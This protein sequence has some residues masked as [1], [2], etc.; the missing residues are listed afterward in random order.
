MFIAVEPSVTAAL[1]AAVVSIGG[2]IGTKLWLDRRAHRKDLETQYRHDQRKHLQQLIARYHGGFVEHAISW[3]YRMLN[4][5]RNVGEPW[6]KLEGIYRDRSHYYFHSTVYRFLALLSLAQQFETEQ[7]FIDAR[8]VDSRE[9]EFV[10]FAKAFHW[11]MSDVALFDGL[12]YDQ[13][14]GHAH[15]KS[16]RLRSICEAF[17][18]DDRMPTF[19][20]FEARV[21]T[22]GVREPEL[23]PVFR[24][25]DGLSPDEEPLRWDRLLCLNLLT[26]AFVTTHGY[27]WQRPAPPFVRRIIDQIQEPQIIENFTDWLPRLGLDQQ[28]CLATAF[29]LTKNPSDIAVLA[30]GRVRVALRRGAT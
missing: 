29:G 13:D 16:D 30:V 23:D 7:V 20:Q 6:L 21:L 4:L 17:L 15:F 9:L 12:D 26:T 22:H 25:F 10:K 19:R 27:D 3:N 2:T 28:E 14:I 8:F 5:F 11:V 1:I 18:E 24:F